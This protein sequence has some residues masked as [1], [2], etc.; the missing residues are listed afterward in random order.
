[1]W[2]PEPVRKHT[3]LCFEKV[4]SNSWSS[5]HAYFTKTFRS[6]ICLWRFS[7]H[8]PGQFILLS[9][10]F[11]PATSL[12]EKEVFWIIPSLSQSFCQGSTP[13]GL[14]VWLISSSSHSILQNLT[15]GL[16]LARNIPSKVQLFVYVYIT[17]I[18]KW[19][20]EAIKSAT[21]GQSTHLMAANWLLQLKAYSQYVH[22]LWKRKMGKRLKEHATSD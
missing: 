1:M 3:S 13:T 22:W 7:G 19:L 21:A 10:H 20:N 11:G 18:A 16:L 9:K 2:D 4:I 5:Y 8:M 12:P 6:M 17:Q 15:L 14:K